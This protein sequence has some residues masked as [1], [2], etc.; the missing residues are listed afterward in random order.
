M[1]VAVYKD[2][3]FQG[4]FAQLGP[5]LY[6]GKDLVGCPHQSTSCED[7]DNAINSIRVDQNI[8][9]CFA[10]S[11]AISASGGGARV[12]IGP[13]EV[14]DLTALGMSNR[15]SSVLV[16]P[17][18]SYDSAIPSPNGG[19]VIYDSYGATGRHSSLRRGDYTSSRL[20]SEEVKLAGK[21][22]V[23]LS[24]QAHVVAVLYAG[25]NF[26]TTLDA[27]MVV[28]PTVVEDLD[29]LGMSG[30]VG[31][32][33]V[34][35]SDPY[36]VPGRP[37]IPLGSARAYTPGGAL[38]YSGPLGYGGPPMPPGFGPGTAAFRRTGLSTGALDLLMSDD[39]DPSH[40][41]NWAGDTSQ[42]RKRAPKKVSVDEADD[43]TGT[44][45]TAS[46]PVQQSGFAATPGAPP[47]AA[48]STTAKLPSWVAVSLVILFIL[49][50]IL[51]T[52]VAMTIRKS[53]SQSVVGG[54]RKED[55][56]ADAQQPSGS[57]E[58]SFDSVFDPTF[59]ED[60]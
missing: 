55:A 11:Q 10:D 5:G 2:I 60:M 3:D 31:S 33:R 46:A 16:V 23:S 13:A 28:G 7:L 52:I 20:T 41:D 18:R 57:E 12:L 39:D 6:A 4:V 37:T 1:S 56:M 45:E 35:Y 47:S 44:D 40:P 34:I 15:I 17:Y 27:V 26:E 22:I 48:P 51:A 59:A 53:K 50:I 30:R 49:L 54:A 32:I 29:R 36:D 19:V 9:V 58:I 14:S 25:D 42:P 21:N 24:V 38:G 43:A 8:V